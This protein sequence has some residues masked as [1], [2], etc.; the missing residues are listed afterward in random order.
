MPEWGVNSGPLSSSVGVALPATLAA[1][2]ARLLP[3]R[4]P[5]TDARQPYASAAVTACV[6]NML[7]RVLDETLDCTGPPGRASKTAALSYPPCELQ[8]VESIQGVKPMQ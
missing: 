1:V 2:S 3:R 5:S 7:L 4:S 6:C 8:D